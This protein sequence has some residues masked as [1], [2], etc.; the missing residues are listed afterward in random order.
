MMPLTKEYGC[1]CAKAGVPDIVQKRAF[2][3]TNGMEGWKWVTIP[4]KG[5]LPG[6]LIE[7]LS[8]Y[9][10]YLPVAFQMSTNGLSG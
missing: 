7:M 2:C 9:C 6:A 5:E 8:S 1:F 10:Y 4:L 3:Q